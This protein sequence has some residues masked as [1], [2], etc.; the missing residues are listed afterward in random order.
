MLVHA[1]YATLMTGRPC[2][3]LTWLRLVEARDQQDPLIQAAYLL[4][5]LAHFRDVEKNVQAWEALPVK[6]LPEEA[7]SPV[8][9]LDARSAG[10]TAPATSAAPAPAIN[11]PQE[12]RLLFAWAHLS[13]IHWGHG[14]KATAPTSSSSSPRSK[15]ISPNNWHEDSHTRTP[16]S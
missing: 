9:P 11:T 1:A 5:E 12:P 13:D 8:P 3:G 15:G 7:M 16:C 2:E 6:F 4:H 10:P 14:G